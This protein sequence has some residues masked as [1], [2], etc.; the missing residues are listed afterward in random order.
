MSQDRPPNVYAELLA[1]AN[2]VRSASHM[3][4]MLMGEDANR[5]HP[6]A[7]ENMRK[8]GQTIIDAGEGVV[9]ACKLTAGYHQ[10]V[11]FDADNMVLP[12]VEVHHLPLPVGDDKYEY[13]PDNEEA[14]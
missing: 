1:G 2:V 11:L 8:L 9:A 5:F 6:E 10:G 13:E 7:L 12:E 3:L 4:A 14:A